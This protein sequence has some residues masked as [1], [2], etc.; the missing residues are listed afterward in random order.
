MYGNFTGDGRYLAQA[1]SNIEQHIVPTHADQPPH[2]AYDPNSPD[3]YA[4]EQDLLYRYA[5]PLEFGV[6]EKGDPIGTKLS[7]TYSTTHIYGM[8]W[9]RTRPLQLPDPVDVQ[10]LI[11]VSTCQPPSPNGAGWRGKPICVGGVL[12]R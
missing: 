4:R 10:V 1:W 5:T 6:P 2:D 9:L 7:A 8:H 12:W 3:T 11:Q